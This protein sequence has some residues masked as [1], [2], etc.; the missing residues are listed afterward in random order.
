MDFLDELAAKEDENEEE[1][2]NT[3]LDINEE[4]PTEDE[5]QELDFS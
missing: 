5:L 2:Y 3:P 4:E 1:V